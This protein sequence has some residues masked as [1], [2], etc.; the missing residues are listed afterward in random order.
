MLGS[1]HDQARF[2]WSR[3]G[4]ICWAY[5]DIGCYRRF[6]ILARRDEQTAGMRTAPTAASSRAKSLTEKLDVRRVGSSLPSR[7]ESAD[8]SHKNHSVAV[9]AA[10][11]VA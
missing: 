5:P 11:N 8:N 3:V 10:R 6:V 2:T 9:S 4:D 7:I 1:E